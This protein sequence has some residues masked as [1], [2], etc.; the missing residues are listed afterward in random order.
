MRKALFT[1]VPR[2]TI[3]S[4][5]SDLD[6]YCNYYGRRLCII[7]SSLLEFLHKN[8]TQFLNVTL[9]SQARELFGTRFQS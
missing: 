4:L 9:V 2:I 3:M 5:E 6:R 7:N 1:Q 8:V